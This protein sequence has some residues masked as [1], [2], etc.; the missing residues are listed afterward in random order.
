MSLCPFYCVSIIFIDVSVDPFF[1]KAEPVLN[2]L[3][4]DRHF[5][6]IGE[7]YDTAKETQ[8]WGL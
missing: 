3:S 2:Y 1:V 7:K 6:P 5:L 8:N 4:L